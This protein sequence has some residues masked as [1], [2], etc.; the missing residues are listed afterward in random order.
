MTTA[1][2]TMSADI[3]KADL[4]LALGY[5]SRHEEMLAAIAEA[6]L[7]QLRKGRISEAKRDGV[8]RLLEQRFVRV[9]P[10][11]DCQ[12]AAR[13]DDR[14][15]ALATSPDRCQICGG[16][17][18]GRAIE[19]MREACAAAGWTRLC[20]V[21]GSPASR[22]QLREGVG[23]PLELRLVEGLLSRT[24]AQARE[25]IAWADHVVV[26]GATQL[27]HKVSLLY[28]RD[29]KATTVTR[30]GVRELCQHVVEAARRRGRMG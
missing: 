17:P 10:R 3:A 28:S 4:L 21:G 11:G 7:S 13:A 8:T 25:D 20:I 6:G 14:A 22:E 27:A 24:R 29:P 26:W 15:A 2:A 18:V 30:R 23:P 12:A 16:S 9:C 19:E 5:A 1:G